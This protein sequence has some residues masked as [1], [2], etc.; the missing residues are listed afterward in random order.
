MNGIGDANCSTGMKLHV[1]FMAKC[2]LSAIVWM[3]CPAGTFFC[4]HR[5]K[6]LFKGLKFGF[7]VGV[8]TGY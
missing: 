3:A 6:V 1:V 8:R 4:H 2:D 5:F 7:K